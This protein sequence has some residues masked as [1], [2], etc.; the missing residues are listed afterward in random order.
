MLAAGDALRTAQEKALRG[1]ASLVRDAGREMNAAIDQILDRLHDASAAARDAI[2]GTVR[3]AAVD[4]TGR[5]LLR[6]G[7]LTSE[8]ESA[9]FGLE[10]F[11]LPPEIERKRR[12]PEGP[13]PHLVAEAERAEARAARLL[14]AAAAAETR[15]KDARLVADQA[16]A[17][18]E[19]AR[20]RVK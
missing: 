12:E 16:M 17:D 4:D 7:V 2:A 11:E 18:A 5:E 8:L 14:E 10:G 3:A 13:D 1:D 9:G 20:G 6:R 15:A 19:A